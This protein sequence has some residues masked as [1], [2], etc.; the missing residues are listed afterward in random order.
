M[1]KSALA[2]SI[3][4]YHHAET[5]TN[6]TALQQ[7]IHSLEELFALVVEAQPPHLVERFVLKGR[8]ATNQD[9]TITFLFESTAARDSEA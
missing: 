6:S 8:D 5:H 1:T 4:V 2:A 9:R 7:Q 3:L